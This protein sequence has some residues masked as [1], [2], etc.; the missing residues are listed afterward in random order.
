MIMT[1][2]M[3][4]NQ[5]D[6][7]PRDQRRKGS[8]DQ[9]QNTRAATS[10]AAA[11]VRS[12]MAQYDSPSSLELQLQ[13]DRPAWCLRTCALCGWL[14]SDKCEIGYQPCITRFRNCDI[15]WDAAR[16]IFCNISVL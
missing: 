14:P 7:D 2:M 9:G 16:K 12:A 11:R 1:T 6:R 3:I 15:I 5:G 4:E 10:A 8:I 13:R